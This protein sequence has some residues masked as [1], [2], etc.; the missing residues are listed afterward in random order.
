M[1]I[2]TKIQRIEKLRNRIRSK[3]IEWNIAASD[4]KLDALTSDIE[5]I[6][7]HGEASPILDTSEKSYTIP[8]G[9][10]SGAGK[11]SITLETKTVT[12]TKKQQKITPAAGKVLSEVT[13]API[14]DAYQDVT[15]VTAGAA[16][17]LA[18]KKIVSETGEVIDGTIP[19]NGDVSAT[20]DGLTTTS[21]TIPAGHT[22]GGT[23]S[24]TSDIEDALDAIVGGE[25][26]GIQSE[27]ASLAESKADIA[28]AIENK[29]VTVPATTKLDGM[30]A[31]IN[32]IP[33][34]ASV[35]KYIGTIRSNGESVSAFYTDGNTLQGNSNEAWADMGVPSDSITIVKDTYVL[36]MGSR[37]VTLACTNATSMMFAYDDMTSSY[38]HLLKITGNNFTITGG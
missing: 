18:G 13:V 33:S 26:S 36:F 22:T 31:L 7:Y 14:P 1:N 20:I 8:K 29:G 30:A 12:P 23:V 21:C 2:A 37:S 24:L 32:S 4:D 34:G 35:E 10:H 28:A 25:N 3:L 9:Y 5:S 15:P 27:L 19:V 17:V 6:A 11:V 16:D 38:W